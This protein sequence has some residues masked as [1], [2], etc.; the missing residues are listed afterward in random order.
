MAKRVW[1]T[2]EGINKDSFF[3]EI[4]ATIKNGIME[5]H[6]HDKT[7][8]KE[9]VFPGDVFFIR[10]TSESEFVVKKEEI[11]HDK[12]ELV[13]WLLQVPKIFQFKELEKYNEQIQEL[14]CLLEEKGYSSTHNNGKGYD[15]TTIKLNKEEI[16]VMAYLDANLQIKEIKEIFKKCRGKIKTPPDYFKR[17]ILERLGLSEECKEGYFFAPKGFV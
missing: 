11:P 16:L 7:I 13:M 12:R 9:K 3:G 1:V 15:I 8:Y 5:I 6:F 4:W 17:L 14:K 2:E 10:G